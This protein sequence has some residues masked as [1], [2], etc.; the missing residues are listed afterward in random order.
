MAFTLGNPDKVK[1][2]PRELQIFKALPR[3]GDRV[4]T[5]ALT[6]R[7]FGSKVPFHAR[8]IIGGAVRS[9][10]RK[11]DANG[12]TFVLVTSGRAG[13]NSMEIWLVE[14]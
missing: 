6:K 2:S 10:G 13:P 12:E 7:V 11:I 5:E 1:Y 4:T 3:D 14:R 8:T 9:L